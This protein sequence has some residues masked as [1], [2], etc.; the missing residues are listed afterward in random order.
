MYLIQRPSD[1]LRW[2]RSMAV[3]FPLWRAGSEGVWLWRVWCHVVVQRLVKDLG[4]VDLVF[5]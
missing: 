2:L 4:F 5:W 3:F 1:L